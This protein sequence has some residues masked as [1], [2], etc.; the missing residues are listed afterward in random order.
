MF[1]EKKVETMPE[2]DYKSEKSQFTKTSRD[3][4]ILMPGFFL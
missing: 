1:D 2:L 4:D 3:S